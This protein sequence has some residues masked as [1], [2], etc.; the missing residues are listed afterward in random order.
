MGF[1]G[2][3][4]KVCVITGTR[5]D[6]GILSPVMKAITSSNSLKLYIVATCMHLM[7][8]FGY[9]IKE[10]EK[11]GFN[12]YEKVNISYKK[13]TGQAMAFS[14]GKA[15]SMFSKVFARLHPDFVL[16]LG[17]RGE[18]LAATIAANYANIPVAHLHGGEVS[19]HIDGILR[20][21]ITKLSHIHFPATKNAKER[22]LKLGEEKY[23]IFKVGAPSI[24]RILNEKLPDKEEQSRKYGIKDDE[25]LAILVQHPIAAESDKAGEQMRI[26]LEAIKKLKLQTILIYPNADAG[27][28]KMISI[29]RKYR[30][31]SFIK[32]LKSIPHKDYLGLMKIARVL[33]GNSSSGIVEAPS[34]HL[35]VVN[36]G[37]RQ[38]GRERSNNIIDVPH[39]KNAI[40]KAIKKALFDNHFRK[41][42]KK[43]R[44][45][46]G[47]GHASERIVKTLS[48]I[49]TGDKLLQKQ[50]TY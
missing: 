18:M 1:T 8:E 21:A 16:V 11:D 49:K 36:I 50:I 3:K 35:P 14:V 44:N 33:I 46:Y 38:K 40:I 13:D 30:I 37:N 9:T 29:I 26:T 17:D 20:H 4:R 31:Y 32:T 39:N 24:D 12:I 43:C 7:K 34:F 22:I 48:K 41:Q 27:G 15:V 28:R 2:M 5:A 6:Y 23:R 10:I 25:P 42:V 47:D 45:I 19:G